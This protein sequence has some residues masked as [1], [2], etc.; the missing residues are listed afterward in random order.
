MALQNVKPLLKSSLT[1]LL[2]VALLMMGAGVPNAHAAGSGPYRYRR[3]GA[4][5]CV[6]DLIR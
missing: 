5:G 1:P 2:A 3:A 6:Q 4:D